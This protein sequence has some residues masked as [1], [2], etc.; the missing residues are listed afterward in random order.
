MSEPTQDTVIVQYVPV[1]KIKSSPFQARKFFREESILELSLNI[2][3]EGLIQPITVRL[4][5]DGAYELIAGERRLRAVKLLGW[6]TIEAKILREVDDQKAAELSLVENLQRVDLNPIEEAQ[7]FFKLQEM[8][9]KK[10]TQ[11]AIAH[12]LGKGRTYVTESLS[13]LGLP[14][15]VLEN[16][17]RPTFSRSH[18]VALLTVTDANMQ[19][20]LCNKAMAGKWSVERL[21]QQ[22]QEV[23]DNALKKKGRDKQ[24]DQ[25][26]KSPKTHQNPNLNDPID[27]VWSRMSELHIPNPQGYFDLIR[28]Y[29]GKYRWSLTTSPNWVRD[30][31]DPPDATAPALAQELA[32]ALREM[33]DALE[34]AA[35]PVVTRTAV[36]VDGGQREQRLTEEAVSGSLI[37]KENLSP[38][39]GLADALVSRPTGEPPLPPSKPRSGIIPQRASVPVPQIQEA[40]YVAGNKFELKW[41]SLGDGFTYRLFRSYE[42]DYPKYMPFADGA[43][44]STLGALIDV[45]P[46]LEE[47][48]QKIAVM[49]IDPQ[50]QESELSEG[51]EFE[52]KPWNQQDS[53]TPLPAPAPVSS[54]PSTPAT[55]PFDEEKA[56]R[57]AALKLKYGGRII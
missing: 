56:R 12:S 57:I 21:E 13:L 37:E 27:P 6:P 38:P 1:E 44:V 54:A 11:E 39:V 47:K 16:V 5:A 14:P 30:E 28:D 49:A 43:A 50:G 32:R 34:R 31:K 29:K 26:P 36:N 19:K 17:G 18:A 52:L 4:L 53:L 15:E 42:T 51:V 55:P 40:R 23:P 33:A 48:T 3:N 20:E 35:G 8:D 45:R 25:E 24:S 10:W 46:E 2:K 9:K 41:S 22:I 7:G